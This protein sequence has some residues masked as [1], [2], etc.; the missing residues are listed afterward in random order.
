[1]RHEKRTKKREWGGH[2]KKMT[3]NKGGIKH[4]K[5]Q[6]IKWD[7]TRKKNK[8]KRCDTKKGQKMGSE[9]VNTRKKDKK[10]GDAT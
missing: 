6:K 1:M 9:G 8:K 5:G 10:D 3:I 4:E 7:D 2:M